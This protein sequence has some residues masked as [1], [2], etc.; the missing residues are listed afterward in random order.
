MNLNTKLVT[1]HLQTIY[2]VS[3]QMLHYHTTTFY[4]SHRIECYLRGL[5]YTHQQIHYP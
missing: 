1:I 5:S 3:S 4:S 2:R